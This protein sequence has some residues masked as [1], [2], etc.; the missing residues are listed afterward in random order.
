MSD[1]WSDDVRTQ[2]DEPVFLTAS[3]I[4]LRDGVAPAPPQAG[5]ARQQRLAQMERAD[6]ELGDIVADCDR[7]SAFMETLESPCVHDFVPKMMGHYLS[8]MRRKTLAQRRQLRADLAV[9]RRTP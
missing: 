1:D 2:A 7:Y 9:L 5:L 8:D 6:A 3:Q 4:A